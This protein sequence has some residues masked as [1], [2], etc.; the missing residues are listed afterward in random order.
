MRIALVT[1]HY[2]PEI[3]APQR[4]WGGLIPRFVDAGHEVM[5]LTPSP[6]YPS[7]KAGELDPATAPGAITVGEHGE[8][9][10]RLRFREHGPGLVSRTIDQSVVGVYT[11][12]RGVR[13]LRR[14]EQ[15][16][17]VVIAT[18]PGMPSIAAGAALARSL[19]VPFVVEMRDAW[20]DLI[21]PTFSLRS[22]SRRRQG[23]RG[24]VTAQAHRG[25]THLQRNAA[26]VV[27][28]TEAFAEVLRERSM[29]RVE[30]VRNGAYLHEI[31]RLGPREPT[32]DPALRVLYLGTV[33]RSQGLST[34]V[35][36]TSIL[37][38]QGVPVRL[39]IVGAGA[40]HGRLGDL[41]A[42]LGAPV[43]VLGAVP[44]S[45]VIDHY[46]WADTLLVSLRAWGPF[47]WTVPSKLYESLAT[48]RHIS[49]VLAGEAAAL[50][51]STRAGNVTPPEDAGSL[52][53]LWRR[54][55]ENRERLE[56]P[57][58]GRRWAFRHADFDVLASR[59]LALL[60]DVVR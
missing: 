28:T 6:H 16:P 13:H 36:A 46:R 42:Q 39:R 19:R 45:E 1:H 17:D 37:A 7:G 59:Y 12:A 55:A 18:V 40:E 30:V 52:A 50:V 44:R 31:P 34:A 14:P 8:T 32:D 49:G 57:D 24:V 21:E 26:A 27:T 22:E 56:V 58:D 29:P 4:R 2:A 23:W 51:R 25:M 3:G 54:L 47:E 9:I 10:Y 35:R 48:S 53:A 11:V 15:R 41:A 43:E 60:E 38:D 20:P 5:V 33:G